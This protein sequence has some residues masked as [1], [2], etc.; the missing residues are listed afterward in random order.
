M[1]QSYY[2]YLPA[3][4]CEH[5]MEKIRGKFPDKILKEK[6]I[7]QTG[8]QKS[9]HRQKCVYWMKDKEETT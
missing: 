9:M 7:A 2:F 6:N 8:S 5:P 4:S 3:A 1:R